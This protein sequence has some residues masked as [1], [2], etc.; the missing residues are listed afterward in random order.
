MRRLDGK[1]VLITGAGRGIGRAIARPCAAE[2][3]DVAVAGRS[4][5]QLEDVATL[6]RDGDGRAF[7]VR[8]DVSDPASTA[9]MAEQVTDA[10]GVPD[11]TVA[12]SGVAGLTAPLWEVRPADWD[13]TYAVN[14][15][16]PLVCC[17]AVRPAAQ[18][19]RR[20]RTPLR[21]FTEPEDIADAIVFLYRDQAAALPSSTSAPG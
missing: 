10:L 7:V 9:S 4:V 18:R 17:R 13:A 14:V 21:R 16:G 3:A 12:N 15:R 8:A 5:D 1:T 20:G 2:G 6:V 19:G 11:A